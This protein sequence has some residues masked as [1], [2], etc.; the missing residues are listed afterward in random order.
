MA[1]AFAKMDINEY[2]EFAEFN[3]LQILYKSKEDVMYVLKIQCITQLIKFAYAHQ[4]IH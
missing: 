1:N 3:A 4:D 2:M